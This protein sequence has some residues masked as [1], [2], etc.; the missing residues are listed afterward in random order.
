M[1]LFNNEIYGLT[2]GQASPTSKTGTVSKTTPL[3]SVDTP[4][5]ALPMALS[6]GAS[7]AARVLDS[8]IKTMVEV[9]KQAEAHKGTA[10]I[11]IL[12]NCVTFSDGIHDL[13][14][15]KDTKTVTTIKL[16]HG[17]PLLYGAENEK[18]FVL[19]GTKLKVIDVT[20][21]NKAEVL[22]FDDKDVN[23]SYLLS[24]LEYPEFPI[25]LGIL[26]KVERPTYEAL[27]AAQVDDAIEKWGEGDLDKTLRG[28]DFWETK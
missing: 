23:L 26:K 17:Q 20:D 1:L 21:T 13:Y 4:M 28:D 6:A 10:F 22:V 9:F 2:K 19:D 18:G 12:F 15:K 24:K 3:G 11:E 5:Q 25:P 7:F 27:Y 8:D 16:T 14:K